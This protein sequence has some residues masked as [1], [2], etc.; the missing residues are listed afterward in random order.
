MG[1]KYLLTTLGCKV[2]QYE[3]QQIREVLESFG[4]RPAR[5]GEGKDDPCDP[6]DVAVVNTCAVTACA[7]RKSR[8]AIRRLARGGRTP[9]L[10]VG[11]G[12]AADGA[13]LR[14]LTGVQ[15]V[16]GHEGDA[17]AELRSALIHCL[18]T[19]PTPSMSDAV[20]IPQP[21]NRRP[22]VTGN[23]VWMKPGAA[24]LGQRPPT[25]RA[26]KSLYLNTTRTLPIVKNGEVLAQGIK[27]FAG[28]QRAFLKVQD[29][30]DAFCTYCIIPRLRLRLRSKPI[31]VAVAEARGLVRAGHKEI[32]VTGIFLGAYGRETAVRKRW[33]RGR[34][35]LADLV[36]SLAQVEGLERLRLSSLEPGDV[37]QALLEVLASHKV[38]VPHLHLS[39]Q[40]GSSTVLRRMNR[41]YTRSAFVDMIDRVRAALDRPAITTDIIVGFA[42]ETE[43][44]FKA[45]LDTARYAEFCKIHAFPF[46]PRE[47]TAAARWQKDFMPPPVVRERMHRLVEVERE[48]SL[49]FRRR[50]I[51]E[52]ERV[53]VEGPEPVAATTRGSR[54]SD[55]SSSPRH[56]I[57]HGRADRYF[58]IH[59]E[60]VGPHGEPPLDPPLREGKTGRAD[61]VRPGD[62]VTV[63][64]DRLTP[65]RTHGML[66]P[67]GTHRHPLYVLS[68]ARAR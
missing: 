11:C 5:R 6:A 26:T 23:E 28:H 31:D 51:G 13:R 16:I 50:F 63:R 25:P 19:Q 58:E 17:G 33:D 34:S 59:F 54:P 37:D 67:A 40:S 64:V 38:C 27:S 39:L 48:C 45:T 46:S 9:V 66:I 42:G 56:C 24:R 47:R 57:H 15:A 12:A 21:T 3:S 68:N 8:Q 41:Q 2:N 1:G 61:D 53:I 32:I 62:L 30:C 36:D 60:T 29:G 55:G 52:V 18:K 44:D 4:L 35:S 65:T 22:Q 20:T 43:E 7:S 10:V 14:K 49:S